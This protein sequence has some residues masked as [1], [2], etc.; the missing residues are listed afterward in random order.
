[1]AI[2]MIVIGWMIHESEA[3]KWEFQKGSSDEAYT[4]FVEK[5]KRFEKLPVPK[6]Q[7]MEASIDLFPASN[8][9]SAIGSHVLKNTGSSPIDTF[10]IRTGFDEQSTF[11]LDRN[12]SIL[13]KNEFMKC[14][15]LKLEE[16][17]QVND[18]IQLSFQ[19]KNNPNSILQRNS[20]VLK[21]GTFMKH[22][23]FPRF[24]YSFSEEFPDPNSKLSY[25]SHY[26][27]LDADLI[28]LSLRV[29]TEADQL[30]LA[31]GNLVKREIIDNR[32]YFVYETENPI[33]FSFGIN[34]G[35][36]Q[37]SHFFE[38]DT[39]ISIYSHHT[40]N[41]DLM[42]NSIG[43]T[44]SFMDT[45]GSY[46]Y[47]QVRLIEFPDS[48]GSYSTAYANN[49]PMS[50]VRFITNPASKN[51]QINLSYYV[52]AH[53]LIH[54]WWG[55][56]L[57]PARAKGA[58]MLTESITEYLSLL[59]YKKQYGNSGAE[60]FL[61][62]QHNRYWAG[63][64]N[65]SAI[66][67]ALYLVEPSEQYISY[68]KGAIMMNCLSYLLGEKQFIEILS[69]FFHQYKTKSPPYPT[70][71]DFLMHLERSIPDSIKSFT[72]G[73]FTDVSWYDY[74]VQ[75]SHTRKVAG[76]RYQVQATINAE[77][78]ALD[79]ND[80]SKTPHKLQQ[81]D[82]L[83]IGFLNDADS[84]VATKWILIQKQSTRIAFFLDEKPNTVILDPHYLSLIKNREKNSMT[85]VYDH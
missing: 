24:G 37:T 25:L 80:T 45:F 47:D 82:W 73:L 67:P 14:Y 60:N 72:K 13:E 50:E 18:Q 34:S 68:G 17:L 4:S 16:T 7:S 76:K 85:V 43:N 58:T 26:Q 64:N 56:T 83:Q 5:W 23:I 63:H 35:K 28:D 51:D 3:E 84:L 78:W 33:K 69:S 36:Y 75:D 62:M 41:T 9:F 12:F 8:R 77:K 39:E 19:I 54:H 30:V 66:E 81:N 53:E 61:R 31:P 6:I 46:Q 74:K 65:A 38:S 57:L 21:N 11:E 27:G 70:S 2:G 40:T 1:S 42:K 15:L 29:T 32:A 10:M 55:A 49:L 20:I 79:K 48:E 59:V 71:V 52:P 22:D 44:L